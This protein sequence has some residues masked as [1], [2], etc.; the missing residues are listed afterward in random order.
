MICE[1][2]LHQDEG[3][4]DDEGHKVGSQQ[5]LYSGGWFMRRISQPQL[6]YYITPPVA[7]AGLQK[8]EAG[9]PKIPK[10]LW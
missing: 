10:I 9:R 4:D 8:R 2:R 3:D 7:S 5:S 1:C 6:S